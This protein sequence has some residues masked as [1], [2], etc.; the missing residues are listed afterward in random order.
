LLAHLLAGGYEGLVY[1]INPREREIFNKRVYHSLRDVP[2][3]VDLVFVTTPA[4][5]V[6]C[7]IRDCADKGVGAIVVISSG[8]R[9]TGGDGAHLEEE[10]VQLARAAK[11]PMVG[12]NTMG[13][14]ST[15]VS[16]YATGA[17]VR[18]A[19]GTVS[20]VSQSGNLGT[21][22]LGWAEGR[23]IG[24]SKFVGSGN[25]ADLTAT[26]YLRFL[27]KDQDTGIILLYLEGSGGGREFLQLAREGSHLKPIIALKGG[28]TR[29]GRLAALS[30]SGAMS[31]E[32]EV[33][34]GAMAQA[35]VIVAKNSSD[36]LNLAAGFAHLPIPKGPRVGVITWGGGWGVVT[37]DE[38]NEAGLDLPSLPA[39]LIER[40]DAYL[41]SFWS[42]GNPVDLVGQFDGGLYRKVTEELMR[43]ETIDA[44]IVLGVIGFADFIKRSFHWTCSLSHKLDEEQVRTATQQIENLE[45]GVISQMAN[46]MRE[47]HKPII[48][49]SM[50]GRLMDEIVE[51]DDGSHFVTYSTPEKAVS[52][53]A[54]L[55]EF[56]KYQEKVKA[57]G[58]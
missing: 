20:F 32:A 30:H 11:I 10:I 46:L 49:V 51:L 29:A 34:R 43:E 41:P 36:L 5:I 9:E 48:G 38:C 47:T 22:L 40:L 18:P 13:I 4:P 6:P 56:G 8:F 23:G 16:L 33:L 28:R 1:P 58:R 35:G 15:E 55:T 42:R 54:K 19:P 26:D 24:I 3:T 25:E 44:V 50:S 17:S 21:Q 53:L 52:V 39:H 45:R 2:G 7:V 14:V 57:S 37:A 31:G 12:P 27:I